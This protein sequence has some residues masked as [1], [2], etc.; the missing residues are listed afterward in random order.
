MNK[1][2]YVKGALMFGL[3][4][5]I[6]SSALADDK[7]NAGV[8]CYHVSGG[9]FT[10]FGGTVANNGTS[11]M[12]VDCPV[13]RDNSSA[14]FPT[15]A[16]SFDVFDRHASQDVSCALCHETGTSGGLSTNC[17]TPA[18]STGWN[19][20]GIKKIWQNSGPAWLGVNQ[21]SYAHCTLPPLGPSMSHIARIH[22]DEP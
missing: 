14:V 16:I 10:R 22:Y 3:L 21:Y 19:A 9:V 17:G 12:A 5:L 20:T 4:G 1:K 18:V 2:V 15:G 11:E 7:V 13:V 6:S 8:V